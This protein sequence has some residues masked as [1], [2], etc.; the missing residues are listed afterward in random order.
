MSKYKYHYLEIK[1]LVKCWNS[2]LWSW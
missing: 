1:K 2:S